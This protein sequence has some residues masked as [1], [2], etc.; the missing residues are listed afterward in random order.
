MYSESFYLA[1]YWKNRPETIDM[2]VEKVLNYLKKLSLIHIN[3]KTW[4]EKGES[5]EDAL[6]RKFKF[7]NLYI[8]NKI[9]E[10]RTKEEIDKLGFCSIGFPISGW[11]GHIK[12]GYAYRFSICVGH[13]S[14]LFFNSCVLSIPSVGEFREKILNEYTS[15]IISLMVDV[16][17][18]DSAVLTSF[19]LRDKLDS[20][21]V[22]YVSYCNPTYNLAIGDL[23]N[24]F[25][26]HKMSNGG[27]LI[28][29]IKKNIS[30]ENNELINDLIRL[31]KKFQSIS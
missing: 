9:I 25:T 27:Q 31:N 12:D 22:G 20:N 23:E 3:F 4:Y 10:S 19:Q 18:P 1:S 30:I 28:Y 17:E 6:K 29:P 11:S 24:L 14:D 7:N 13:I 8:R 2:V 5:L 21:K 16:F 15:D 26:Y